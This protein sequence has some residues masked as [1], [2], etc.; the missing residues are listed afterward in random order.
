M[1]RADWV[2]VI[3]AV[4]LLPFLYVSYWGGNAPGDRLQVLVN[5]KEVMLAAL[6]RDQDIAVDGPL[7][8]SYIKV[9]GGRVRFTDSPCTN[10]LCVHSGWLQHG[11]EFA[12]CLPNRVSL[13][14]TGLHNRFD[15]I[16]F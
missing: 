5:G 7:G 14:V 12:A 3:A 10:K 6:S 11:G 8:T 2:I 1:T 16:N 9:A 4:A 15:T 13:V